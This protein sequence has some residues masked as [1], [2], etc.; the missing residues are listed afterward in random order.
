MQEPNQSPDF[1][2]FNAYS[3]DPLLDLI[4]VSLPENVR[5]KL[6]G[7]GA[8]AGNQDTMKLARLANDNVPVLNT[9]DSK[10]NRLDEVEF[11]PAWHAL[12]RKGV[13]S[14]LHNSLW[15][16]DANEKDLY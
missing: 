8:W 6:T 13:D 1:A 5:N 16:D 3:H 7:L 14:G 15:M 9:H 12:M 11:H 2:G 4:T 10:G